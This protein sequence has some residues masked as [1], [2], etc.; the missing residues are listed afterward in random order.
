[1][2]STISKAP[3]LCVGPHE[4][5]WNL[6]WDNSGIGG[7]VFSQIKV[8][9]TVEHKKKQ[10]LNLG[11]TVWTFFFCFIIFRQLVFLRKYHRDPHKKDCTCV[12]LEFDLFF[13]FFFSQMCCFLEVT[14]KICVLSVCTQRNA[15]LWTK[16]LQRAK[17][18]ICKD[19]CVC[20]VGYLINAMAVA[21]RKRLERYFH[22]LESVLPQTFS[23]VF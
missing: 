21:T 6:C 7:W 3:I 5:D 19:K 15:V 4:T 17:R 11:H 10:W 9:E 2:K 22:F 13:L 23:W 1:M 18:N 8:T 16:Y 14:R 12:I 20:I